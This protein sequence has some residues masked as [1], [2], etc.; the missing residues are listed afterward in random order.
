VLP[1]RLLNK[2]QNFKLRLSHIVKDV[3]G[4]FFVQFLVVEKILDL[5]CENHRRNVEP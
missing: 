5:M 4:F 1:T 3:P 2:I